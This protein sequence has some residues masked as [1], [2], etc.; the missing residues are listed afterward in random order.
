[1]TYYTSIVHKRTVLVG[2]AVV[3]LLAAGGL[4]Y[5][6]LGPKS[7]LVGK[8]ELRFIDDRLPS[9][10]SKQ[11]APTWTIHFRADGTFAEHMENRIMMVMVTD[12]KGTYKVEGDKVRLTGTTTMYMD[13][14]GRKSNKSGPFRQ[15]LTISGD[16]LLVE[17]MVSPTGER[18]LEAAFFRV[19]SPLAKVLEKPMP[20]ASAEARQVILDLEKRY[21]ALESYADEG[22]LKSSGRGFMAKEARFSTR[23]SRPG[24]FRFKVDALDGGKPYETNAV[25]SDGSKSWLHMGSVG[26]SDERSIANGLGT[27]S[28]SSGFEALL[29]PQLLM[30]DQ[31]KGARLSESIK[32]IHLAADQ[33][34]SGVACHV[35]KLT[36]DRGLTI[37]LWID[38]ES[39]L[40]RQALDTE[41]EATI[42]YRPKTNVRLG[43][44]DF[45]F[46]PPQ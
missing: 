28:P 42:T 17:K 13:D 5:T 46:E 19:G 29:V 32:S 4:L 18:A 41:A 25:W 21:A 43:P 23:F 8:W 38:R 37:T 2:I 14:G 36:N 15:T 39:L 31:F 30:P 11:G 9:L 12:S 44:K 3:V 7:P 24:K 6:R 35:L 34:V 45:S 10:P 33:P 40:I 1:M 16:R 20:T 22:T 26:G 27:I